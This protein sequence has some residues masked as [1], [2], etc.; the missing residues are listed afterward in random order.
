MEQRRS[1]ERMA[2]TIIWSSIGAFLIYA[3]IMLGPYLRSTLVRDAAVTTWIHIATSPIYG[4]V[5]D[6]TPKPGDRIGADGVIVEVVNQ[7]ADRTAL[8][9][10]YA[11][12][13]EA[14]SN[15][16]STNTYLADIEDAVEAR[17]E[18]AEEHRA[19]YLKRITAELDGLSSRLSTAEADLQVVSRLT[20]RQQELADRGT[21]AQTILDETRLR[22]LESERRVAELDAEK[23]S[24][25]AI[26]DALSDGIALTTV[27]D[28]PWWG[29]VALLEFKQSL[30]KAR[31]DQHLAQATLK[32]ARAEVELEEA[33]FDTLR[34]G[35]VR[36]PSDA[37][38]WSMIVGDGAAVDIG[39]PVASWIDCEILLVDVP[40]PDAY[41]ALLETDSPAVVTLEGEARSR[42]GRVILTRGSAATIGNDD[43]AAVAKGRKAGTAQAIISL[44]ARPSDE[45]ICPVGRAAYVDFP[46]VGFIDVL[47]AR[48]RL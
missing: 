7:K 41:V 18:L 5:A 39:T 13:S 6:D 43:L 17:S 11:L 12:E 20:E 40:L 36:A 2:R 48:L 42:T 26:R 44:E 31:F 24:I 10:A 4:E 3:A 25:E 23:L 1:L 21:A 38:L 8:D 46:D 15:E 29:P 28:G 35:T 45:A 22:L 16:Q 14:E 27:G 34:S 19:A 30:A 9:R 47:R 37:V 32:R 33:A